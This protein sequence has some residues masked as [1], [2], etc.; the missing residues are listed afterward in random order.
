MKAVLWNGPDQL[1]VEEI[2]D[3]H[4]EEGEVLLRVKDCGICGSDLHAAKFGLTLSPGCVMGHE[5]SGEIVALGKGVSGWRVG[6]RV[7]SL[8][9]HTCGACDR[10]R[11]G[12]LSFC[13][14]MRA[15][16]FGDLPGAYAAY[17]RV[18]PQSLLRLP[19]SVSDRQ[20][21]LVEP[22]AVGLHA[23][24]QGRVPKGGAVVVMGAGPIGLVTALWARR[25]G[26]EFV[27]VS[28]P[29][30]GRRRLAESLCA[31]VAV[32]PNVC[33]PRDALVEKTGRDPDTIFECV[34]VP[35]TINSAIQMAPIQ[36]RVVVVGVCME[37]DTI[38]PFL[39]IMKEAEVKFV[40][41]Y[42]KGEFQETVDALADGS[43]QADPMITDV[44]GVEGVPEA[45]AALAR[46][47]AQS[48]ILVEF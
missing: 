43:I 19:E 27:V 30:A 36:G 13:N 18:V 14:T 33:D 34:G 37:P 47:T 39:G 38:M 5:F 16:G 1:S 46:P 2:P 44:I 6:E 35:G 24:R 31:D 9:V 17:T 42:T 41:A 15:M 7:V 3:P 29:V 10:C 25:E 48:K 40:L 21:A 45:F 32:D 12:E 23:V 11:A 20:G 28:D 8:P 26:A 22:L 4:P